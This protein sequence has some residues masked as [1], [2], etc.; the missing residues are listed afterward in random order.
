MQKLL[1]IRWACLAKVKDLR[2][3]PILRSIAYIPDIFRVLGDVVPI[4]CAKTMAREQKTWIILEQD[5]EVISI[6]L[7]AKVCICV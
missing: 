4:G 5:L 6:K 7:E 1:L 2:V 3:Q